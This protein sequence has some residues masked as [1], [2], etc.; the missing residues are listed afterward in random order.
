MDDLTADARPDSRTA[1]NAADA[2]LRENVR[3]IGATVGEM[4]AE[5]QGPAFLDGVETVRTTAI[6]RREGSATAEELSRLL[7]G[8]PVVQAEWLTRVGIVLNVH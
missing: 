3:R 6:R 7:S 5:Q 2:P 8:L 1:R 4:L